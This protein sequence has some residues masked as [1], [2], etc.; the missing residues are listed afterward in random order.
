[1]QVAEEPAEADGHSRNGDNN[2]SDLCSRL[3]C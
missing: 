3:R 2:S 1:M